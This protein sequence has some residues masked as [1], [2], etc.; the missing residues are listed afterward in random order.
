MI[1]VKSFISDWSDHVVLQDQTVIQSLSPITLSIYYKTLP[2][3]QL[4]QCK[5]NVNASLGT[6]G[7]MVEIDRQQTYML[8]L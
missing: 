1:T 6:Q 3:S 8:V 5:L 4:T 7:W 2:R